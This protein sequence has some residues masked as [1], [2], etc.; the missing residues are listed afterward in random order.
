ML[1][2][3]ELRAHW[4]HYRRF[5]RSFMEHLAGLPRSRRAIEVLS[6]CHLLFFSPFLM[7]LSPLDPFTQAMQ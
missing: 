7:F 6:G 2:P 4:R 5:V 1:Y 3:S